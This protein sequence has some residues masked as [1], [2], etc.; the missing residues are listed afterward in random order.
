MV[1][2]TSC[3]LILLPSSHDDPLTT[4]SAVKKFINATHKTWRPDFDAQGPEDG[5][6]KKEVEKVPVQ[7]IV[8]CG[9][10]G[11]DAHCVC[12]FSCE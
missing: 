9:G 2:L 12:V 10:G 3:Q 8:Y 6:E 7:H 5:E 1:D 11:P 4:K